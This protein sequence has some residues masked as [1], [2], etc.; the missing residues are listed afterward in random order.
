M[1]LSASPASVNRDIVLVEINDST[2]RDLEPIFGHW[3]WPRVGLAIVIDYLQRA[4]AKVIAVDITLAER[5]RVEQYDIGG[6]KWSG[7]ESDEALADS[8]R[9]SGNVIMLAD[10]V[11]EG[12]MSGDGG[13]PP[14]T[15]RDPG[16]RL[17]D[18]AEPRPVILPPFDELAQASASSLSRPDHFT[19]PMSYCSTLSRSASVMSTATTFAGALWR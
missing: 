16:Y 3:P 14:R 15:W 1:R 8:V 10:A 12:L 4:P 13:T 11:D 19:P 5:D 18:R 6:V 7:L 9:K 2:I 17:T